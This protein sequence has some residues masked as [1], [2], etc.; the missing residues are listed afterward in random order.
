MKKHP[1]KTDSITRD[2][3]WS[4]Y[5]EKGNLHSCPGAFGANY[6]DEISAFWADFFSGLPVGAR[7]LDIGTGNGAIAFLARDVSHQADL[8]FDIDGIDAAA[9][10]PQQA[11]TLAGISARDVSFRSHVPAEHTDYPDSSFDAVASQYAVEYTRT[12][13]TLAEVARILKPG[14]LLALLMHHD[15]SVSAQTTQAELTAFAHMTEHAPLLPIAFQLVE[16]VLASGPVPDPM[17]IMHDPAARAQVEQFGKFREQLT[18][19]ASSTPGAGFMKDVALRISGLLQQLPSNGATQTRDGLQLLER[20]M[21]AHRLRLE[22]MQ[23]ACQ[24]DLDLKN[25]QQQA[26]TIG[27]KCR[28]SEKL[29]RN[30]DLVGWVFVAERA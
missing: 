16:R 14:G 30:G 22:S 6:D 27:L 11:A 25:F 23:Q 15:Q 12:S 28:R 7:V 1:D 8:G 4:T 21:D 17:I 20:E 10:Q 2:Q 3:A 18:A 13:E 19:Y 29:Y 5:W 9:I 26:D 24:S